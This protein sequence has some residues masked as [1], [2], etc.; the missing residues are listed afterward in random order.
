MSRA[1]ARG[2][3]TV[4]SGT[5]GAGRVLQPQDALKGVRRA[6]GRQGWRWRNPSTLRNAISKEEL[7]HHPL[8]LGKILTYADRPPFP[9]RKTPN[10]V[11]VDAV[12]GYRGVLERVPAVEWDSPGKAAAVR[13]VISTPHQAEKYVRAV[14]HTVNRS[15]VLKKPEHELVSLDLVLLPLWQL[16]LDLDQRRVVHVNAVTGESESYLAE[17][18]GKDS[19]LSVS[20]EDLAPLRH[21]RN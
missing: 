7:I 10:V 19:W 18:W 21:Q 17:L 14:L 2:K 5:I 16:T 9:P 13:T 15:Y 4:P 8:W 12:S 3:A 20:D 11:F 6:L 1:T